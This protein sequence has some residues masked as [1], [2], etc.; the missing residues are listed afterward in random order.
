V[1]LHRLQ[2]LRRLVGARLLA[3][4]GGRI[5]ARA[6]GR[7]GQLRFEGSWTLQN[8]IYDELRLVELEGRT[9]GEL[10]RQRHLS[11]AEIRSQVHLLTLGTFQ[12]EDARAELRYDGRQADYELRLDIDRRHTARL[13]GQVLPAEQEIRLTRLDMRLHDARW[14][15]LQPATFTYGEAY[16][17]QGLLLY[18]EAQDQQLRPTA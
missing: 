5:E 2:P 1:Q 18:T 15:L 14:R 9:A 7:P 3:L 16:R 6:Y 13:E 4:D 12:I 17:I 8:L 10:D 11:K